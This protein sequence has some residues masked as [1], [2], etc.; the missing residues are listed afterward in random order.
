MAPGRLDS[1]G[2][3]MALCVLCVSIALGAWQAV[4]RR[5]EKDEHAGESGE[6]EHFRFQDF[7]RWLVCGLMAVSALGIAA[8]SQI[9]PRAGVLHREWFATI[10]MIVGAVAIAML[11]LAMTDWMATIRY[12]SRQRVALAAQKRA[13]IAAAAVELQRQA[14]KER[15]RPP[16]GADPGAGQT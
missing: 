13:F 1:A 7:R 8:G 3:L 4:K 5:R 16:Q 11:I 15:G 14:R 12:A 2:L 10:W 9:N 6:T